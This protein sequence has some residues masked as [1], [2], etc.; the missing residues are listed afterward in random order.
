[1]GILSG[2]FK[3]VMKKPKVDSKLS[4]RKKHPRSGKGKRSRNDPSVSE[5]GKGFHEQKYKTTIKVRVKFKKE[6]DQK[7]TETNTFQSTTNSNFPIVFNCPDRNCE[8]QSTNQEHINKHHKSC[9]H[10]ENFIFCHICEEAS[11]PDICNLHQHLNI[12]HKKY[13]LIKIMQRLK[14]IQI[15]FVG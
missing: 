10:S 12:H 8:F 4:I 3:A 15:H 2:L 14:H 7:T 9:H 5:K 11:F 6:P 13:Q 1:M